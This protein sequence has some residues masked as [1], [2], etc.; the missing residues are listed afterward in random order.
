MMQPTL[1]G[2]MLADILSHFIP[3]PL[4]DS[5]FALSPA[6]G[7]QF[8][9]TGTGCEAQEQG[10]LFDL[11]NVD[12]DELLQRALT[13]ENCALDAVAVSV[14]SE[15]DWIRATLGSQGKSLAPGDDDVLTLAIQ[16]P[17]AVDVPFETTLHLELE[18][19]TGRFDVQLTVRGQTAQ[20]GPLPRFSSKGQPCPESV[21]FGLL[22]PR[23]LLDRNTLPGSALLLPLEA[24][25]VGKADYFLTAALEG[26]GFAFFP[27][28][29]TVLDTVRVTP[30]APLRLH[31][32]PSPVP[33]GP[34]NGTL[35]LMAKNDRGE[36]LGD[37][38]IA[39][40]ATIREDIPLFTVHCRQ[41]RLLLAQG[42]RLGLPLTVAHQGGQPLP[43]TVTA[44]LGSTTVGSCVVPVPAAG[45]GMPGMAEAMLEMDAALLRS[46]KNPVLVSGVAQ[47]VHQMNPYEEIVVEVVPVEVGPK[48][49]DFGDL[50]S[51]QETDR[52][53]RI[54]APDGFSP[55]FFL[56]EGL[57]RLL[58]IIPDGAGQWRVRARVDSEAMMPT[59]EPE[60]WGIA[61]CFKELGFRQR[62][63]VRFRFRS[64]RP[65]LELPAVVDFGE[66]ASGTVLSVAIPVRNQTKA[67]LGLVA[68]P[69]DSWVTA[70]SE[71]F[72]VE[73]LGQGEV[74]L[75]LQ[76]PVVDARDGTVSAP[77][78]TAVGVL[79]PE[80][81]EA[82]FTVAVEGRIL[83]TLG[84]LCPSCGRV[85]AH[86]A[87]QCPL[88]CG[89]SLANALPAYRQ[90]VK[91]CPVCKTA[92]GGESYKFCP[93]H[94]QKLVSV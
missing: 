22:D 54:V 58:S 55:E 70:K 73:A 40:H 80:V 81:P 53:L 71:S 9:L 62:L 46:G 85:N 5:P 13:V 43:V 82:V 56:S 39:L 4:E 84:W 47:T 92:Y 15:S 88:P 35:R 51:G 57:E 68:K 93:E 31:V 11:G 34:R 42:G 24:E 63:G 17:E 64:F 74:Q 38:R 14:R 86:D 78:R 2:E 32:V 76:L 19:S 37:V 87:R 69:E 20:R 41:E 60:R 29:Q 90:D 28:G 72:F 50:Q 6:V 79:V 44:S 89:T 77:C 30:E 7:P 83:A 25:N 27:D 26:G 8:L 3:E 18:R 48:D 36:N 16:A 61:V 1:D 75:L 12:S 66:K 49:L 94:G 59:V 33:P 21:D 45:S 10:Y 65:L 52:T 23:L 91:Q 67:R